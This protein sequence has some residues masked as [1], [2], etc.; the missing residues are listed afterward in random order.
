MTAPS[1]QR[2]LAA[3]GNPH[4]LA[5][6]RRLL[7]GLDVIGFR[8]LEAGSPAPWD[9]APWD[10]EESGATF[11]ENAA[12]KAVHAS[13]GT[14]LPVV[15][16]DSG[17]CVDHLGGRPGVHSAR[18]GGAGLSDEERYGLLLRELEGVPD[19]LRTA[20][21]RAVVVLARRG[22]ILSIHEGTV[23]GRVLGSPRGTGGFGYDPVFWVDVLGKSMAELT[24]HEK[25]SVSH[26]A[27]AMAGLRAALA[28][29]ILER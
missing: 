10:V 6:L 7:P 12:I 22:R 28:D 2:L 21:Y 25:D 20:H 15:A 18:H 8:E 13:R 26:R 5:E 4:K 16:D 27:R 9:V 14:D 3:T 24:P 23:G 29:G 19:A 1:R 17:L 11:V